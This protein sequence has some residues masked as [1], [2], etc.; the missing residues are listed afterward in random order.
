MNSNMNQTA[1]SFVKEHQNESFRYI[2]NDPKYKNLTGHFEV[3]E[4]MNCCAPTNE[5]LFAFVGERSRKVMTA[6]ELMEHTGDF[7]KLDR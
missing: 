5:F 2:G 4:D 3:I 1:E 6:E 7:E